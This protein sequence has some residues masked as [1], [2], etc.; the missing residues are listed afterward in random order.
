MIFPQLSNPFSTGAGGATFEQLVGAYYLVALL[1]EDIPRGLNQGITKSVRFQQSYTGTILDDIRVISE[2]D[3]RQFK[4][5]LQVK[6]DLVIGDNALFRRV[7]HDAW[8]TFMNTQGGPFVLGIDR[9]GIVLGEYDKEVDQHLQPVLDWARTSSSAE[10]FFEKLGKPGF[11]SE[12]KRQFVSKIFKPLLIRD[13]KPDLTDDELFLFLKHLTILHFDIEH[14]SARDTLYVWN[15]LL[16][17]C[18]KR[19]DAQAKDLA[20]HLFR[21]VAEYAKNAAGLEYDTLHQQFSNAPFHD[22]KSCLHDLQILRR[23]T[24]NTLQGISST[25]GG[26]VTL[27][28][29]EVISELYTAIKKEGTRHVVLVEEAGCGKSVLLKLLADRL[30][31]ENE[32]IATTIPRLKGPSI[33]AFTSM[34]QLELE[35]TRFWRGLERKS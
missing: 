33:E 20:N 22:R 35:L 4:L 12:G 5:D 26:R 9:L 11:A 8:G 15:R 7:L 32:V 29:T 31:Q 3:H 6:H 27:P 10:E 14:N 19:D 30:R 18:K 2:A 17:L 28:R 1:A 21:L 25:I 13:V 16:D 24:D 34:L 23:H